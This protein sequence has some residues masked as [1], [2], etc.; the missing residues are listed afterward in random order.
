MAPCQKEDT[1]YILHFF[2]YKSFGK[3]QRDID[4]KNKVRMESVI[5]KY[6]HADYVNQHYQLNQH[7]LEVFQRNVP[8]FIQ[9]L[10]DDQLEDIDMSNNNNN[11]NQS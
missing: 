9:P 6:Y 3:N 11:N 10:N 2:N 8:R 1:E 7:C 5:I 4:E